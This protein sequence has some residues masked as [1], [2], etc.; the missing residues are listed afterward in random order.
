MACPF[1]LF[2][3]FLKTFIIFTVIK[4]NNFFMFCAFYILIWQTYLSQ[5]YRDSSFLTINF[6]IA[7][8]MGIKFPCFPNEYPFASVL[9]IE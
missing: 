3:S 9:F 8:E 2:I 7:F 6:M 1:D 4:F 5:G